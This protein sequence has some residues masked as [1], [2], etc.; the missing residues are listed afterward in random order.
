[1]ALKQKPTTKG[2]GEG[3]KSMIEEGANTIQT[4]TID[5]DFVETRI[6]N[7]DVFRQIYNNLC[8][9]DA[10]G[11]AER[12]KLRSVRN[13]APP[14]NRQKLIDSAQ[15]DRN[16]VN[17]GSMNANLSKRDA[18]IF[19]LLFN[20]E[21]LIRVSFVP[22]TFRDKTLAK[23]VATVLEHAYSTVF[24][25]E[26]RLVEGFQRAIKDSHEGGVGFPVWTD[27]D[28]WRFKGIRRARCTFNDSATTEDATMELFF[29]ADTMVIKV[30][31]DLVKDPEAAEALGWNDEALRR[32]LVDFFRDHSKDA[33]VEFATN[34]STMWDSM[35]TRIHNNDPVLMAE[36]YKMF[37]VIHGWVTEPDGFVT[38]YILPYYAIAGETEFMFSKAKDAEN[39]GQ[40][41]APL[42]Y[43]YGDGQLRSVKG[44][45]YELFPLSVI[46]NRQLNAVLDT[47]EVSGSFIVQHASGATNGNHGITRAGAFT[48]IDP[49]LTPMNQAFAPKLE[50]MLAARNVL[51]QQMQLN[52][53]MVNSRIGNPQD[54][55][56]NITAAQIR[57]ED[58]KEIQMEEDRLSLL[59]LRTDKIH[60]ETMRRLLDKSKHGNMTKEAKR[61]LDKFWQICEAEGIPK[62]Y[63]DKVVKSIIVHTTRSTGGTSPAARLQGLLQGKQSVY[64]SM[65]EEGR[66]EID[67]DI[68]ILLFG[69][70]NVD[71]F[72]PPVGEL[73]A[74]SDSASFQEL[75]NH[76]ILEGKECLVGRDQNHYIHA[77]TCGAM[78]AQYAQMFTQAPQQMEREHMIEMANA[79]RFG[80][81]HFQRHLEFLMGDPMRQDQVQELE[82]FVQQ[83]IPVYQQA[84]QLLEQLMQEEEQR[85]QQ[86]EQENAQLKQQ[87]AESQSSQALEQFKA[88]KN[89]ELKYMEAQW[90]NESRKAKTE[91]SN[92]AMNTKL[93][94]G[95]QRDMA[96]FQADMQRQQTESAVKIQ[97]MLQESQAKIRAKEGNSANAKTN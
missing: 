28:D 26:E 10:K 3:T 34:F 15:A 70:T 87:L 46:S 71:R 19:A 92:N 1:M 42:P 66:K 8:A 88:Q 72:V 14:Y 24:R 51:T 62:E 76:D 9:N 78:L 68:G 7:P 64:A 55:N 33:D 23:Q 36:Q 41:T 56:P 11:A 84:S 38:H 17:D 6:P 96:K 65:S 47:S 60:T 95:L 4:V 20:T 61:G 37:S 31:Y 69:H 29:V 83:L 25:E 81:V 91:T 39:M 45:A 2:V 22:G 54:T 35:E 44:L 13:G 97:T 74:S 89:A 12:V 30:L 32:A 80:I 77:V 94:N 93:I 16:N 58:A 57:S 21:S 48:H 90:L 5:G 40:I 52:T 43:N 86:L 27:S 59:Y 18:A 73:T 67:R 75:E 53:G 85:R 82:Q 63:M 50:G 49:E 79:A